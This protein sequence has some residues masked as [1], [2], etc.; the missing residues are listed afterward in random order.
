[1][2]TIL[3]V[4]AGKSSIFLIEY[5]L[6]NASRNKWCVIVADGD[7][8]AIAGKIRNHPNAEAAVIDITKTS[9]REALV[10]RA[11]IVLSLMPPH[12]H[13][14]LAED[15]LKYKKHLITSSYISEEMQALNEKAK[16]AGVMFMCEMGL[17]PGIDHMIA[18]K[19]I[20]SVFKVAGR[21]S[22]FKSYCGGLV[23]PESDNNPWHYKFSWNPRNVVTAGKG[24]AKFLLNGKVQEVPYEKVFESNKK[25]KI[26]NLNALA[27]YPN[28]DSMKYLDIYGIQEETKTFIRATLRY[29]VFCKGWD[30]LIKLGFTVQDDPIDTTA[31]TYANWIKKKTGYTD[32]SISVQQ[33]VANILGISATD[34]VMT[35][36]EWLGVF[37]EVTLPVGKYSSAEILEELLQRKWKMT[38]ND[39]DMVVMHHEIE[40]EHRGNMLNLVSTMVLTGEIGERTAMARC[41]GL[42]I[43]LLTLLILTKKVKPPVGVVLPTMQAVYKPVLRELERF[44][45]VFRDE[46]V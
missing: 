22:S 18:S 40:Y 9:D 11:D 24:G 25:I 45:I 31:V 36:I 4:G 12:L 13:I 23:A 28:R 2:Q 42:P 39:K 20:N 5:L 37:D 27:Y 30:A 46:I 16:E 26:P 41:V 7:A 29:P 19:I 38:P 6:D 14:L 34:Q 1:M 44:G 17:D 43:G 32:T 33:H 21:I 35:L 15:C 10:K 8:A 3:V